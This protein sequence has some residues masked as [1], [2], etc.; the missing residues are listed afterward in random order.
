MFVLALT[1]FEILTS[2]CQ[3]T[4][5]YEQDNKHTH[6]KK[7]CHLSISKSAKICIKTEKKIK[8]SLQVVSQT[9]HT[10]MCKFF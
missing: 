9:E 2:S 6:N 4:Y 8:I 5:S 10:I 7:G 1:V 3:A